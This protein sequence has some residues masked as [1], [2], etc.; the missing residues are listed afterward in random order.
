VSPCGEIL[1]GPGWD[2]EDEIF[3]AEVDFA[4]C[5]PSGDDGVAMAHATNIDFSFTVDGLDMKIA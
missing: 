1:G 3:I 5:E 4:D 2:N